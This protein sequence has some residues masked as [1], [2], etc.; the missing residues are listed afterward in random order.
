MNNPADV[1][2]DGTEI[3]PF[4]LWQYYRTEIHRE[5]ELIAA[6]TGWMMTFHSLAMAAFAIFS[7]AVINLI[8]APIHARW[9]STFLHA[10]VVAALVPFMLSIGA[11]VVTT[12]SQSAVS[13][14]VN[15]ILLWH[16]KVDSLLK[17]NPGLCEKVNAGF[18]T[19]GSTDELAVT[20]IRVPAEQLPNV[21]RCLWF[22]AGLYSI[23]VIGFCALL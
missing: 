11:Y 8:N 10:D 21:F 14:A 9:T 3:K 7:S 6:R 17:L 22:V 5:H 15:R 4:E 2:E 19:E 18:F 20:S 23:A 16:K 13:Q 1:L 12:L